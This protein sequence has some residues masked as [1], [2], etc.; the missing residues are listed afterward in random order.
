MG[1]FNK[2]DVWSRSHKAVLA[3]YRTT[4]KYPQEERFGL[5]SQLRR[6]A[7]SVPTNIAEGCG[8]IHLREYI[9]FLSIARGSA[10]EVEYLL[11]ISKELKYLSTEDYEY[12]YLEYTSIIKMINALILSLKKKANQLEL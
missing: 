3:V 8:R 5:V 2:L 7:I 12:L 6:A 4:T 11:L 9:N 10:M 1:N